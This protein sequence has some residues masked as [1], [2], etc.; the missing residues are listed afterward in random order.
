MENKEPIEV[1]HFI[2]SRY[3]VKDGRDVVPVS[4][5]NISDIWL[6]CTDF[7]P[8]VTCPDCLK[9]ISGEKPN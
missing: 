6:I 8:K 5:C 3:S 4:W 7:I 9:I 1:V 2:K